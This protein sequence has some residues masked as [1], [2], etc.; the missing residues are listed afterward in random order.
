MKYISL[1]TPLYLVIPISVALIVANMYMVY[2]SAYNGNLVVA[3]EQEIY[4]IRNDA[5]NISNHI[6]TNNIGS[7]VSISH[8]IVEKPL[9]LAVSR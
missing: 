9:S 3:K 2:A 8:L 1:K 5:I 6:S 4:S 7:Q